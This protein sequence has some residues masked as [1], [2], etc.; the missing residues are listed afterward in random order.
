MSVALSLV[1]LGSGRTEYTLAVLESVPVAD[2]D[3]VPIAVK[4]TWL[5]A[6]K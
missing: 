1:G 4:T 6:G 3:T 2:A 5:P